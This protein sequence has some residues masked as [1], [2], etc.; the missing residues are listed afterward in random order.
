MPYILLTASVEAKRPFAA[1]PFGAETPLVADVFSANAPPSAVRKTP[2]TVSHGAAKNPRHT[3]PGGTLGTTTTAFPVVSKHSY[4]PW[5]LLRVAGPGSGIPREPING[6]Q[7]R[8]QISH[9][10]GIGRGS[11]RQHPKGMLRFHAASP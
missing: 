10:P 2:N 7:P 3:K 5:D 1:V 11:R 6:Q 4:A 8:K 9:C